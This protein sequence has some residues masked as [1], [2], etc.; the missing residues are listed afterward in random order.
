MINEIMTVIAAHWSSVSSHVTSSS[1]FQLNG[2]LS[3]ELCIFE[4]A[5]TYSLHFINISCINTN[6]RIESAVQGR[7]GFFVQNTVSIFFI[8]YHSPRV[9]S[10]LFMY[11]LF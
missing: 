7:A 2:Q 10:V 3:R 1:R 6:N 9:K 5:Y 4:C 11:L 8:K